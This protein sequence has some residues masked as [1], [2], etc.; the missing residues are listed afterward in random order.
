VRWPPAHRTGRLFAI[1]PVFHTTTPP[2]H[3]CVCSSSAA[4]ARGGES[5]LLCLTYTAPAA[6]PRSRCTVA[7]RHAGGTNTLPA[8]VGCAAPAQHSRH[9]PRSRPVSAC[10]PCPFHPALRGICARSL[11]PPPP[12][13]QRRRCWCGGGGGRGIGVPRPSRSRGL[14]CCQAVARVLAAL[15]PPPHARLPTIW[16]CPSFP[17]GST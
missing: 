13:P 3:T 2:T 5:S 16:R 10:P 17:P 7:L 8:A 6:T 14:C 9:D 12:L 4:H 1:S 11:Q 15:N